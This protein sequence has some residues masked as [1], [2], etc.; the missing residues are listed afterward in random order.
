MITYTLNNKTVSEEVLN[1][2]LLQVAFVKD[3]RLEQLSADSYRIM[4]LPDT[5]HDLRCLKGA[6]LDALVDIYGIKGRFEI[7]IVTEDE[8][9]LPPVKNEKE[10]ILNKI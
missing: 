8:I 3:Y 6:I 10:R 2:R 7:D 4:V 9:L 1:T 5:N